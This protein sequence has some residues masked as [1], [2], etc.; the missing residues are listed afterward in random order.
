LANR[1]ATGRTCQQT[2]SLPAKDLEPARWANDVTPPLDAKHLRETGEALLPIE[3][4]SLRY[5]SASRAA[6]GT[7]RLHPI[8]MVK[9]EKSFWLV[10]AKE[11]KGRVVKAPRTFLMDRGARGAAR[12]EP[13]AQG[14]PMLQ[15]VLDSGTLEFFRERPWDWYCAPLP[16]RPGDQLM[17]ND[18]ETP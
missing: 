8:R 16:Y 11:E 3:Q 9:K 15:D 6:E 5:A 7:C 10:A 14:V 12:Q 13:V 18:I 1:D 4:V 2:R 17:V